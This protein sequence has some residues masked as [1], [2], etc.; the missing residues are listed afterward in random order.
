M[1][2]ST[3]PFLFVFFPLSLILHR[4]CPKKLRTGLLV[5]LSLLFYAW[6][7]V[8]HLPVLG[9]SVLF[10]YFTGLELRFW[11]ERGDRGVVTA[12]FWVSVC[13]NV[14]VLCYYKYVSGVLPA[15]ISFYTFSALS[16]I[17]DVYRGKTEG[18]KNL[19][20]A[21]LYITFFPKLISGPIAQYADFR[22][23]LESADASREDLFT[24]AERFLTG[25]FKKVLLADNLGKAFAAIHGMSAMSAA[26]AWLGVL[27][28]SFQLYYDFS[29]YSDMAIGL[30]RMLGFRIDENFRYPYLSGNIAEFWRRWHI[31]LGTWFR[32][33]IY[34]PL[35]GNRRGPARQFLNLAVVW[36][37]TGVWHGSTLNFLV[38]GL[39]HGFFIVLER[40]ALRNVLDR[41]PHA[42]RVFFTDLLVFF[43]WVLFFSPSL[44]GAL[45][46]MG[47]L[48]GAG[49]MGLWDGTAAY[50]LTN[51]LVLLLAALL[52]AGPA[53]RNIQE[54]LIAR[55]SRGG[56]V[57]T[58]AVYGVLLAFAVAGMVNATYTTFLY[59][60]F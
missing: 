4:V 13:M 10:N 44:G 55:L 17:A 33:Y 8:R 29:G 46:Y 11:K 60:Q 47:Q 40:F 51:N 31:S 39:Y 14:I 56:V 43:G 12:A 38:W 52:F 24:G 30:A 59:F 1:S 25:L 15:G 6:G 37:L 16:Y 27:F 35:G 32:E 22:S 53:I 3:I 18:E 19:L 50:Y 9:F 41:I 36:I 7:D 54:N 49:G 45:A 26:S 5:V 23:Q 34:I 57:L 42:L 28:Y 20:R 2:F 21:A 48:F 58:A